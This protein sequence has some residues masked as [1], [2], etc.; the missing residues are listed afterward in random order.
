MKNDLKDLTDK[1][2][3]FLV[4]NEDKNY[5][6]EIVRR[7]KNLVFSVVSRMV[8]DKEDIIDLSQE[9]FIKMYKN[10]DKYSD[11]FKFSTWCMRIATNHIID[12][13]RKKRVQQ[14][15]L[16]ENY[17]NIEDSKTPLKELLST[18]KS[19]KV[20]EALDSLPPMYSKVLVLY[21]LKGFSYQEISD[22]IDEPLSK[23]KN[24][25]SRGRKLL[26]QNI[27]VSN[28]REIYEL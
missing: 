28:E 19:D 3:I 20:H 26:K 9:I 18:E 22:E 21:H 25:I 12:F 8:A 27:E 10:L 5:Y 6:E 23:V 7:Y 14:V 4:L 13:R 15:A 1:E 11:E 17:Y 16:T 2:V 24:R